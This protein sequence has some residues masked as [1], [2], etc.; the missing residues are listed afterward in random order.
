MRTTK[1]IPVALSILF[2]AW[3]CNLGYLSLD[4]EEETSDPQAA[5]E[6]PTASEEEND[7]PKETVQEA[8]LPPPRVP[9]TR[10]LT[11][12]EYDNALADLLGDDARPG[13]ALSKPTGSRYGNSPIQQRPTND[14]VEAASTIARQAASTALADEDRA[15]ELFG[16]SFDTD[17]REKCLRDF[18]ETFGRR[19]FRRPVS[20]QKVQELL[21]L[22]LEHANTTN[23]ENGVE[24]V[25]RGILQHADFLYR[26]AIGDPVEGSEGVFHLD[27]YEIASRMSFLIW[28]A[29]PDEA[30]LQ[31]AEAGELSTPE[32]RKEQA[33][34]MING[35]TEARRK[36]LRRIQRFHAQ[37]LGYDNAAL[38]DL[39]ERARRESDKLVDRVIFEK[40]ARW[41]R[42]FTWEESYIDEKLAEHYD[43]PTPGQ[44]SGGWVEY[45]DERRGGILSHATF[46]NTGS[47]LGEPSPTIRGKQAYETLFCG[48]IPPPPPNVNVDETSL[49]KCG[50]DGTCVRPR[51]AKGMECSSNEDCPEVLACKFE[52]SDFYTTEG[53][54]CANCHGK[55]DP[56]GIGLHGF[57]AQGRKRSHEKVELPEDKQHLPEP[58]CK[59]EGKGRVEGEGEFQ[60]P[61][62]LGEIVANS[63]RAQKCAIRQ[64]YQ[65]TWG[66]ADLPS[67][68]HNGVDEMFRA[69]RRANG[70]FLQMLVEMVG[71]EAFALRRN[72]KL[73][74]KTV[75]VAIPSADEPPT[76][77]GACDEYASADPL[78]F[79][80]R[81][82]GY[83]NSM[84][85]CRVLWSGSKSSPRLHG[86]CEIQDEQIFAKADEDGASSIT[87]DD[88]VA[89]LFGEPVRELHSSLVQVEVNVNSAVRDVSV[90]DGAFDDSHDANVEMDVTETE[91]GYTLEWSADLAVDASDDDGKTSCAFRVDDRYEEYQETGSALTFG[92]PMEKPENWGTCQLTE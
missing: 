59:I 61:G 18:I 10:R 92:E 70:R 68:S 43:M 24:V 78:R 64:F 76:V 74:E 11:T 9:A 40:R 45:E 89:W 28:G 36:T 17:Q 42:L 58:N 7:D 19:A 35:S 72:P 5:D 54:G 56:I 14:L 47:Q 67:S 79:E 16:C 33:R 31:A 30:L 12:Y 50:S 91:Q 4:G 6:S 73:D 3:G 37:W 60:G 88:G 75:D 57:D 90:T 48:H 82:S 71:D 22:G 53:T 65:F 25:I 84:E 13:E 41:M 62:E 34:R 44:A 21:D 81:V 55:M 20:D 1:T 15:R 63:E 77:D 52:H 2:V 66:K 46:L 51:A 8:D 86:C 80:T 49:A 23:L 83:R 32:G 29:P 38:G 69:Y 27:D 85:S 39:G 87:G 26:R